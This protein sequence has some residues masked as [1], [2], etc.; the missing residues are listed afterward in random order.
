MAQGIYLADAKKQL[1]EYFVRKR[2][3]FDV[4]LSP[5]GS[6]FQQTVWRQLQTIPYGK[7]CSYQDIALCIGNFKAAR[8]VGMANNRNPVLI[9]IPCHRVVG[10]DNRLVGY[11]GGME[12]KQYLLDLE[13]A[14]D[15]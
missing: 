9:M 1:Q 11:A 7:I 6:E 12:R 3:I 10:K 2:K 4:P 5:H 14:N 15:K 13:L 8:A